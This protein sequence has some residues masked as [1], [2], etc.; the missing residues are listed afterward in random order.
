MLFGFDARKEILE[1]FE[2]KCKEDDSIGKTREYQYEIAARHFV[3]YLLDQYNEE[4]PR[5]KKIPG[6]TK[7]IELI[8]TEGKRDEFIHN[9][10]SNHS[11]RTIEYKK[12]GINELLLFANEI[13]KP[14]RNQKRNA[15]NLLYKPRLFLA[16]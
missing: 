5:E 13:D 1:A 14:R 8:N 9:K 7:I 11:P 2:K 15:N 3:E 16:N 6:F 10:H 12:D 4:N